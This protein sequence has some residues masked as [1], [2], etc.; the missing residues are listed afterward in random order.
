MEL[1]IKKIKY[2]TDLSKPLKVIIH[3][4]I[5]LTPSTLNSLK[6]L[7]EI[8]QINGFFHP[9]GRDA[10]HGINNLKK[11]I[12]ISPNGFEMISAGKITK[13]NLEYLHKKIKGKYYHGKKIVGKL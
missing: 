11:M 6:Q 10:E 3:K 4:A 8:K 5:D 7:I 12:D 1:D 9:G 2:L 13:K